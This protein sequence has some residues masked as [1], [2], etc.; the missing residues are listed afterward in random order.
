MLKQFYE[1]DFL[2]AIAHKAWLE[3]L[4][5]VLRHEEDVSDQGGS[6]RPIQAVVQ[7][8]EEPEETRARVAVA[9]GLGP[10]SLLG[11]A[12]KSVDKLAIKI[13]QRL[14]PKLDREP[15]QQAAEAEADEVQ[16]P[17]PPRGAL[18]DDFPG[19]ASLVAFGADTYGKVRKLIATG[20]EDKP[21]YT[22]VKGIGEGTAPQVEAAAAAAPAD[23]EE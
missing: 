11:K 8:L 12:E 17:A 1:S 15:A 3:S 16:P 13:R 4:F 20:T 5:N 9:L 19:R 2:E 6:G 10:L 22:D 21:W 18:A 7:P 14:H 23:E